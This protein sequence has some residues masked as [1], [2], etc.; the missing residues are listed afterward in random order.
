MKSILREIENEI[1]KYAAVLAE[2]LKVDIEIVDSAYFRVAGTGSY[3][4][5][6]NVS[7]SGEAYIISKVMESGKQQIVENPREDEICKGCQH[8]ST[9]KETYEVCTPIVMEGEVIGAI[10]LV[11][12]TEKQ[13]SH[14]MWHH[15][16]FI[17]FLNQIAELIASKAFERREHL[18]NNEVIRLLDAIMNN[19]AEGVIVLD[20]NGRL[21]RFN[22]RAQEL[23]NNDVLEIEE[24]V[25]LKSITLD[26]LNRTIYELKY[27]RSSQQVRGRFFDMNSGD[28]HQVFIFSPYSEETVRLDT[29]K[30]IEGIEKEMIKEALLKHG[31]S[32]DAKKEIAK[33]LNI[34]IATLYR[35]IKK[36]DL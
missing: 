11:C 13:K 30:T 26:R 29:Y 27:R 31:L 35:K 22:K 5:Q 15:E 28:F 23:I 24:T 18:K 33:E 21:I 9:C 7:L 8:R 16:S 6:K 20:K 14:I 4:E 32:V 3:K 2:I 10:G 34:G 19:L 17:L 12:F 36:Y 1:L 25:F